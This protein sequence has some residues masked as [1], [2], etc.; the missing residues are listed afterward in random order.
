MTLQ[1]NP[2]IET[3]NLVITP[4][5]P[6][7]IDRNAGLSIDPT[8]NQQLIFNFKD[9]NNAQQ[10]EAV[11]VTGPNGNQIPAVLGTHFNIDTTTNPPTITFLEF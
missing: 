2:D 8:N 10:V 9:N 5:T 4:N 6:I 1:G 11:T 7:P 3:D